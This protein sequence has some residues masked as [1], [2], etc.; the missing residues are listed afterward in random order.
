M[1]LCTHT[2]THTHSYSVLTHIILKMN[3]KLRYARFIKCV[4][5]T[6]K[7]RAALIILDMIIVHSFIPPSVLL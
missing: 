1:H 5:L 7:R 6:L 3:S 2:Y 4:V